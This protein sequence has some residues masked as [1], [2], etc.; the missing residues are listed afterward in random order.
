MHLCMEGRGN[1]LTSRQ[2]IQL[3]CHEFCVLI[4]NHNEMKI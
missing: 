4:S 3:F 1:N 2:Q